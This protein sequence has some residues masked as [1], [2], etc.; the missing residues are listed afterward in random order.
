MLRWIKRTILNVVALF[1]FCS[2]SASAAETDARAIHPE[3]VI[4]E[5]VTK[6]VHRC[7]SWPIKHARLQ[8]CEY[9][10]LKD[11]NLAAVLDLRPKLFSTCLSC[12]GSRCITNV[13]P[14]GKVMEKLLC[15]RVFWTPTRVVGYIFSLEN[16]Q[17]LRVYTR[18]SRVYSS[19]LRVSFTFTISTTGR[20]E[21]IEVVS[22]E[23]VISEEKLSELI[24]WG[25]TKTRYEPLVVADIAYEI[26]GLKEAFI[27]DDF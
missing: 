5:I 12:Q 2:S 10:V 6:G 9:E 14:E 20:V 15:R 27:L 4:E 19:A 17:S 22:F 16:V 25:A 3:E 24:A 26:V 8:G 18:A 13:W 1:A 23:G 11:E 21:N 7:G